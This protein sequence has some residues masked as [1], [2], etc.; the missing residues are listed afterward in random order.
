MLGL[1][2]GGGGKENYEQ[3]LLPPQALLCLFQFKLN[4]THQGPQVSECN[5]VSGENETRLGTAHETEKSG[6]AALSTRG[7]YIPVLS[8]SSF[9]GDS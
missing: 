7:S 9:P 1:I 8:S 6:S 4:S 2:L 3:F 5:P